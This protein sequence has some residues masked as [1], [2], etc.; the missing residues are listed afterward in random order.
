M[1]AITSPDRNPRSP[2]TGHGRVLAVWRTPQSS[3]VPDPARSQTSD[4][5]HTYLL[6][7]ANRMTVLR[8]WLCR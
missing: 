3:G 6:A 7:D 5:A 2:A 8:A 1:A 4:L